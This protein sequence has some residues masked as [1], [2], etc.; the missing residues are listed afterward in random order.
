MA[1]HVARVRLDCHRALSLVFV[2]A[3]LAAAAIKLGVAL[4]GG[5]HAAAAADGLALPPGAMVTISPAEVE[6]VRS[7]LRP[8]DRFY[9]VAPGAPG[10]V[11]SPIVGDRILLSFTLLPNVMVDGPGAADVVIDS[12]G[13]P[14]PRWIMRQARVRLDRDL[15]VYRIAGRGGSG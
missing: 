1:E 6:R 11:M 15:V 13:A 14:L 10:A 3:G 8:G 5:P 4:A 2:V 9:V 12:H 7:L